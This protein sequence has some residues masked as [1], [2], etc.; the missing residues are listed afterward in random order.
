MPL[1]LAADELVQPG[2]Q[3]CI[4]GLKNATQ[5][6]GQRGT[7]HSQQDERWAVKLDASG[8]H[9]LVRRA[10]L[11]PASQGCG[12]ERDDGDGAGTSR[13]INGVDPTKLP[14]GSERELRLP[15][16]NVHKPLVPQIIGLRKQVRIGVLT[17]TLTVESVI[18]RQTEPAH[19]HAHAHA[20][21]PTRSRLRA[22]VAA[23]SR[24]SSLRGKAASVPTTWQTTTSSSWRRR[25]SW[26]SARCSPQP[27]PQPPPR[28]SPSASPGADR[29]PVAAHAGARTRGRA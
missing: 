4:F 17:L 1:R 26:R 20:H 8:E 23:A 6:N 12:A 27:Q 16:F 25:R 11:R 22:A 28:P 7:I 19:A 13:E 29:P 9:V 24:C 10:N 18:H 14:A 15:R 5:L 21:A 2:A 3:V